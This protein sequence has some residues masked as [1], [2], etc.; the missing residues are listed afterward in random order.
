MNFIYTVYNAHK[1]RRDKNWAEYHLAELRKTT[2]R[3]GAVDKALWR[4]V[5]GLEV[6]RNEVLD[7]REKEVMADMVGLEEEEGVRSEGVRRRENTRSSE[8]E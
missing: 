4:R 8:N 1:Q 3:L 5:Y 6:F 7:E 2:D